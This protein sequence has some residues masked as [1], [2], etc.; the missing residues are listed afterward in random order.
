M[1]VEL[2]SNEDKMKL[3][4]C[5]FFID[6]KLGLN[7]WLA[8]ESLLW[9]FLAVSALYFEIFYIDEVD[10]LDFIEETEKWYFYL[11]FGDQF[12]YLDQHIRSKKNII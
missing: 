5:C 10:L 2:S 9:T 12:S 6:L 1:T 4:K 8:I 11:I 3:E 7:V